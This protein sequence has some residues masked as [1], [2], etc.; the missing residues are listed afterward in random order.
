MFAL[1]DGADL[2]AG[3]GWKPLPR[4]AGASKTNACPGLRPETVCAA[5]QRSPRIAV[6]E[7]TRGKAGRRQRPRKE[8]TIHSPGCDETSH[9][10]L[11][12]GRSATERVLQGPTEAIARALAARA[13]NST[14]C[15][16]L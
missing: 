6:R 13:P 16:L 8:P 4:A 3:P 11:C 1:A 5:R 9:R 14:E 7:E 10:R 12:D 2:W 15:W